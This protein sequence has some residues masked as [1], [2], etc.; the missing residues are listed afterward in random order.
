[1]SLIET[2]LMSIT[3]VGNMVSRAAAAQRVRKTTNQVQF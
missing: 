1:M 3:D 2:C